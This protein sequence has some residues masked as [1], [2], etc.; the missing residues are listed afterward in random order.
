MR[1]RW[2]LTLILT[3]GVSG[4]L[5][6]D[7]FESKI[8][9]ILV[10]HCISCHGPAKQK[11]GLRLDTKA[12]WQEGGET[13]PAIK[14]GKPDESLL[15]KAIRG[16]DGVKQMPPKGKL[17]ERELTALAKWVKDGAADPRVGP[18]RIGG[19]SLDDA[20]KWWAFQP[21]KR[22]AVPKSM[23]ANPVDAFLATKGK[24]ADKRTLVRRATYDLTGLPP[25]VAEVEAFQKDDS[26]EAF[27]K[28]VDRLLASPHYGERW[29]R[30]WLDLVRYA[31][32]AG[33]NS[34]HPLPHAWRYR[35]W[36]I[37]A[38]NR[39]KPYDEF[40]REQ[41]AGDILAAKGPPEKYAE[42]VVATGFVAMARRF[43][44]DSDKSMH[45]THEDGIDTLGKALLGLTIGCA[46]CHD[47]KYDAISAKDY[48]ALYGI[49]ESTKFAF[50]G[51]E[52]KQ[53]PRDMVPLVTPAEWDRTVKP[54][55]SKLEMAERGITIQRKA[56]GEIADRLQQQFVDSRNV[57]S[58][59]EIPDG[60]DKKFEC[61]TEVKPGEMLLLSILPLKNHGADSTLI[62][63]EIVDESTKKKWN[64]TEDL[65]DD[66]LSGNPHA[67]RQGNKN[68]WWHFD[69]RNRPSPL[70]ETVRNHSG[71][72]GLDIWRNGDT[73]SV[74][75]NAAKTETQVWTKL[76]AR[77]LFAHPA[78]DGN[79]ALGWLSPIG[80]KIKIVGRIKDAHP[81]GPDGV[82]W[83]LER[84]A[85]DVREQVNAMAVFAQGVVSL[86]RQRA[87]LLRNAPKQDVA[88]AVVE[89]TPADAKLHLRGDP[90]KLGESVPRR[91]LEILGGTPITSGSGRL[92]L[93]NWIASKDNPLTAR[94]MANRIWLHHFGKGLVPTP[95][96][97]GTRGVAPTHPELLDWLASEFVATGWSV[98]KMHRTI[99]L[100]NAYRSNDFVRRRLSA[101]EIRDSLLVAG[102]TLD[103]EPAKAHPFPPESA[104]NYTQHVPFGTFFETNKRS[105]Y[106]VNVR[107]RRH[108]FLGLFDGADPNA[109]TPERQTT[110][111][112]TQALFF[113]NDPFFHGQADKVAGR[114]LAKSEAERIG[115]LF[116]IVFQREP[117]PKD[118]EF[119]NGFLAEYRSS[120]SDVPEA[121]REKAMWAALAR[122]LLASNEFLFVE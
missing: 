81:G 46:R 94:V 61:K 60:G 43:D 21:V 10:E 96:D 92:D 63:W 109:T 114:V 50:P 108:P 83:A 113:L 85:T 59:G 18:T 115:E 30:H 4:G 103:R 12:G 67:D 69:V 86:E 111:V 34:D 35:N 47:H 29:G 80:G 78:S 70:T 27:A 48:Y 62:E 5:R 17:P 99:L 16:V 76:P 26:P 39:D 19:Q 118:G 41:I 13:G 117:K 45:L 42:R 22:P 95:N 8:R 44:H 93:A 73:P 82:G 55:R 121:G 2:I 3:V 122:V 49:F 32:T 51:C 89:G 33:E 38:V 116:R 6:A 28:V 58:T 37:D 75:V 106:L 84:F 52:A 107:N 65:L 20:K 54:Y 24:P 102:G 64:A 97:F 71:K 119:A 110:T 53:Q 74:W 98:K 90:E 101:E 25:T 100:S 57:L 15:I 66:F 88:Y 31:D 7:D 56:L 9:P 23:F 77:S 120:L 36:V 40:L 72:A 79:V 14:P 1:L 11:G 104:W 87:E 91:W 68:I 112:P 105:V